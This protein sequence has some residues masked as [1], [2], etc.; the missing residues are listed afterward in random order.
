[1]CN[2]DISEKVKNIGIEKA[3]KCEEMPC[4]CACVCVWE[5]V[6]ERDKGKKNKKCACKWVSL[7]MNVWGKCAHKKKIIVGLCVCH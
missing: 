2:K 7:G 6:R 5:W 3:Q 1:M 4:E